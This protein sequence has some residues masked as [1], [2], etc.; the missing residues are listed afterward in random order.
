M[1]RIS[2]LEALAK[3]VAL[4]C[5]GDDYRRLPLVAGSRFVGRV[6]L[7]V[8]QTPGSSDLYLQPQLPPV[9]QI[10]LAAWPGRSGWL[11]GG[12]GSKKMTAPACWLHLGLREGWA[13]QSQVKGLEDCR[14]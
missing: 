14:L 3:A 10:R 5:L 11:T 1:G 12:T 2:T 4:D 13:G 6:D 9:S 7:V 8:V